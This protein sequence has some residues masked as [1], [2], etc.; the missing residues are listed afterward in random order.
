[1]RGC[2]AGADERH[3]GLAS[4]NDANQ[5]RSEVVHLRS[6]SPRARGTVPS[7]G[8]LAGVIQRTYP[9]KVDVSSPDVVRAHTSSLR[10]SALYRGQL[11]PQG[12]PAATTLARSG[13]QQRA[14]AQGTC[15]D[16]HAISS[17]SESETRLN[18]INLKVRD[19]WLLTPSHRSSRRIATGDPWHC[20]GGAPEVTEPQLSRYL[21]DH[22]ACLT[23][24]ST[25]FTSWQCFLGGLR[26]R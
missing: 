21:R 15:R 8:V 25:S 17:H 10:V 12:A 19:A 3:P 2:V 22:A 20:T 26:R 24:V 16:H 23:G 4:K 5:A 18:P 13:Q 14:G 7:C 11:S 6:F 1:M 9:V